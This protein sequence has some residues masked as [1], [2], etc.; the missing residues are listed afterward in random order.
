MPSNSLH[1]SGRP[2]LIQKIIDEISLCGTLTFARFMELALYD[3]DHG[4]YMTQAMEQDQFSRERIGWDGDFYTAPELSPILAK[5]LVRQVLDIDAQIG[6]PPT[7]TVIEMGG[8]NGTFAADFLQHCQA[9][10]PDFLNRLRYSLVER[11]PYLQSLQESRI[12]QV[13]GSWTE[14]RVTWVTSVEQLDADSVIGLMFSNEL[15]DAFPVHR[16]RFHHQRLQEVLV[17]YAEGRFVE[18]LG[19]LSSPKIQEYVHR[20]GIDLQEGQTSEL[21]LAAEQWMSQMA[22]VLQQGV[23]ITIDYGHTGSDYYAADRNDGTLLCYYQHAVSTNPYAR[24]GE[25]DMTAHVNFSAL[26]KAGKECGLLPVGFTTLANW[27]MGLGVEEMVH[28]QD[29][30]SPEI[31]ALSQLLRPHGMGTTFKVFVQQKGSESVSLEGLR[32]RAFFD[33]V[34]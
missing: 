28:D 10:A 20:H 4:Y 34:L 33:D 14:S 18:R 22:R 15:V 5:T 32:Y 8:G 30:E 26:A 7:F 27:L 31:Q 29:P 16:V 9:I 2:K 11:S 1:F 3:K 23:L 6:H 17:D 24:V 13:L 19:P 21:H 25:Q 12:Q